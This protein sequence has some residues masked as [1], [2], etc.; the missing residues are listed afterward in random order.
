MTGIIL[1][2]GEG[3]RLGSFEKPFVKLGDRFLIDFVIDSLSEFCG[4]IIIVSNNA[5][6]F[7]S[8]GIKAV[9]DVIPALGPIGGIYTGLLKAKSQYSFITGCDMPFLHPPLIR[10]MSE[11]RGNYEVVVPVVG[12]KY[13]P[14][15][16]LY[17]RRC[18]P[19]IEEQIKRGEL[20]IQSLY[21]K[22]RVRV[23]KEEEI[24]RFD[25][26][27]FSFFNINTPEDLKKA[28]EI[29]KG[30]VNFKA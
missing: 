17:S 16:A 19:F 25:S 12:G 23:I 18:L 4:G 11:E 26:Q 5:E 28:G 3:K 1:A 9:S 10:F 15:H 14:L 20:R 30:R 22:V 2:G 13:E 7:S 27:L 24:R 29:L 21:G 6:R 8:S